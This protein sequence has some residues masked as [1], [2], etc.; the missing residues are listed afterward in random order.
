MA[1]SSE[2]LRNLNT[3]FCKP[4]VQWARSRG[5]VAFRRG[6]QELLACELPRGFA[7]R[8]SAANYRHN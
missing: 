5:P 4:S 1:A 2:A 7:A 8:E 6:A 3:E